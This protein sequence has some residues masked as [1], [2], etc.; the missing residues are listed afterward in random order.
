MK[1]QQRRRVRCA[2]HAERFHSAEGA[3]T[4]S[5]PRSNATRPRGVARTRGRD[6]GSNNFRLDNIC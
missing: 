4:G 6:G 3:S 5:S 2:H 1:D